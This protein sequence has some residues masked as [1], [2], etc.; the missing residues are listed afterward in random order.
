MVYAVITNSVF[1][2]PEH[3]SLSGLL[4]EAIVGFQDSYPQMPALNATAI[5]AGG[6]WLSQD[7]TSWY[8][9]CWKVAF[10]EVN[11][12]DGAFEWDNKSKTSPTSSR[13]IFGPENSIS[14]ESISIS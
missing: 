11:L 5:S 10:A 13:G 2:I 1:P 3:V 4:I 6:A 12:T 7:R 9:P 14:R 8:C